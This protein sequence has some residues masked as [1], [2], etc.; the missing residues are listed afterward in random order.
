MDV[1]AALTNS[2]PHLELCS[3]RTTSLHLTFRDHLTSG[4][5]WA[6]Y[7]GWNWY[8]FGAGQLVVDHVNRQKDAS[9]GITPWPKT[10]APETG[11]L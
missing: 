1:Y 2:H 8:F 10:N 5:L 9:K 11:G 4:I 3:V 6:F 7:F